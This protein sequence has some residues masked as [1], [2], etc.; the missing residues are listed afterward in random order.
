MPKSAPPPLTPRIDLVAERYKIAAIGKTRRIAVIL[1]H[2]YDKNLNKRYP[3][4]YL[5]D[6]QNLYEQ[7]APYGT[8]GVDKQLA[9]LAKS[10]QAGVIVVAIDHAESKRISEFNPFDHPK[11]GKGEGKKYLEFITQELKPYIDKTYRTY[12]DRMSTAMGGSSMG[13]LITAYAAIHLTDQISKFMIFSPSLWIAPEIYEEANNFCPAD[14][15]R[16]Y[17]YGGGNES[18]QLI[19]N[20]ERFAFSLKQNLNKKIPLRVKVSVN[21]EGKHQEYFW[22]KEFPH[23]LRWLF[24]KD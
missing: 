14:P 24:F 11:F 12:P 9:R 5:Q 13:G 8:W 15:T 2:D 17:I 1:P 19:P 6:G 3:V 18:M 22:G 4:L 10:Q 23:A 7:A 20:I 21:S 16:I